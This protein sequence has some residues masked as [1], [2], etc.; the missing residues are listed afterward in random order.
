[1]RVLVRSQV[2]MQ[3]TNIKNHISQNSFD[4]LNSTKLNVELKGLEIRLHSF[5]CI[6]RLA[7]I[8]Q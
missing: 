8:K 3:L 6:L 2:F 5:D 1:M 4:K 7:S